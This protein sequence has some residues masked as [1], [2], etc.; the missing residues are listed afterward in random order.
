MINLEL[1]DM[2]EVVLVLLSPVSTTIKLILVYT[3]MMRDFG[4]IRVIA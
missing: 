2:V 1:L 4:Q 3:G